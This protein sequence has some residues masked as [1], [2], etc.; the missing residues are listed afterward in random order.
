M[1]WYS[2]EYIGSGG[3]LI[4]IVRNGDGNNQTRRGGD[5]VAT[6][7]SVNT[8]NGITMIVSQLHIMT[9]ES[10]ETSSVTCATNGNGPR[11]QKVISFNTTGM[12]VSF[13]TL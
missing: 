8:V 6:T 12:K 5:T 13:F 2:E 11:A 3:D 10:F 1:E 7:V 9:S 4:E